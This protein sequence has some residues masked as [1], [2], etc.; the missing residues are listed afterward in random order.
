MQVIEIGREKIDRASQILGG[1]KALAL[2]LDRTRRQIRNYRNKRSPAPLTI[3]DEIDR[4]IREGER[5]NNN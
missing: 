2:R 4:I 5:K 3:A 1:D